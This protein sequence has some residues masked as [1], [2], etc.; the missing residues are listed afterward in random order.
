MKIKNQKITSKDAEKAFI[1][2]HT[3]SRQ[4]LGKS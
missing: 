3:P 1:Y 4:K 2:F